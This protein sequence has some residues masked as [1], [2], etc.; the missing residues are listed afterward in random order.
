MG[1]DDTSP[2]SSFKDLW[3]VD[4][5]HDW[6]TYITTLLDSCTLEH[7]KASE[8]SLYWGGF[9][10]LSY[11]RRKALKIPCLRFEPLATI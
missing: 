7:L 2:T 5:Y 11:I 3:T 1:A 4:K 10:H 8:D 9:L 6:G